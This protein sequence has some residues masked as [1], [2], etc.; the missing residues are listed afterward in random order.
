MG[1]DQRFWAAVM[2]DVN[3]DDSGIDTLPTALAHAC[4]RVLPVAGVMISFS[5]Q[6]R[7]PLGASDAMAVRAERLETTLGD[8]PCLTAA[9]GG[10]PL[11]A[12]GPLLADRWPVFHHELL[13]QTPYRSVV[14]VPL[15]SRQQERFGAL[16]L[17]LLDHD[18]LGDLDLDEVSVEVGGSISSILFDQPG[19]AYRRGQDLPT[20]LATD[21]VMDRMAI[22]IVAGMLMEEGTLTNAEALSTLRGYAYTHDT[23]LDELAAQITSQQVTPATVLWP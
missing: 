15:R 8:G 11:R 7:I 14:S 2:Q 5:D 4:L 20:W 3:G 13:R 23:T 6:L 12:T 17:Y 9:S 1:L 22:W 10:G 19:D 16:D 21:A 18:G